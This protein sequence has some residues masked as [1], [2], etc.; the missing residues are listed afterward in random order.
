MFFIKYNY[1]Y[2]R[3][4]TEIIISVWKYNELI[5]NLISEFA[6]VC[7]GKYTHLKSEYMFRAFIYTTK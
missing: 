6:V 3:T 5:L 2:D 4:K 7:L 1:K